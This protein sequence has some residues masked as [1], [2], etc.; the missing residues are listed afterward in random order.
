VAGSV[1]AASV[2]VAAWKTIPSWY[3]VST[4]DRAI[5]PDLERFYAKRIHATTTEIKASHV[6][7]LSHPREVA[8]VIEDATNAAVRVSSTR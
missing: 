5:N 7:F 6:A 1:F 2:P 3:I 8:R 4:E